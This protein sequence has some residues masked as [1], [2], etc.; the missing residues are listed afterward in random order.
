MR[1]G[2]AAAAA[3]VVMSTAFVLAAPAGA[4]SGGSPA[5]AFG[6]PTVVDPLHTWGEPDVAIS[7]VD[8]TYY[9]SGPTGTGTQ[10]SMWEASTDGGRTF[11]PITPAMAPLSALAGTE[12][13]PGGGDTDLAFDHTGKQYFADLYALT[14]F[15]MATTSDDGASVSQNVFPGGCAGTPGADRQWFAMFD[16][17]GGV[18]SSAYRGPFPLLYMEYRGEASSSGANWVRSNDGLKWAAAGNPSCCPD[19]YPSVDQ[20]TGRILQV[21]AASGGSLGLQIGTPDASGNLTFLPTPATVVPAAWMNAHGSPDDLFTVSSLDRGRNLWVFFVTE[22]SNDPALQQTWVTVAAEKTG[23]RTWAPPVQVSD[24]S[25][26][27][28]DAVNLMPWIKAGSA[29]LA[30]A[31]WYGSGP[32]SNGQLVDANAI[33]GQAW[34]VFMSQLSWPVDSTGAVITTRRPAHTLTRVSPHPMHYN[35]VCES[36]T[37]CII[38]QGNRNLADF[39]NLAIDPQ[40]AAVIVYDD[41]SNQLIQTG[42]PTSEQ[43][44][45]HQGA[46]VVTIAHQSA[47]MGVYGHLVSG[48][49]N[50][51]T[52]SMTRSAGGALFPVIGGTEVP[53]MDLTGSTV[54]LS[55]DGSTLNISMKVADLSSI[56]NTAAAVQAPLLSFVT[57]WVMHGSGQDTIYYAEMETDASGAAPM[58]YAGQAQSVDLCSVSACF[59]HVIT[60]PEVGSGS[61]SVTGALD[62]SS[63]PC[64]ISMSVPA[65]DVGSPGKD[66]RLEEVG[67]YAFAESHPMVAITNAQAQADNVPL[68]IGGVCCYDYQ[69]AA[70]AAP[71]S[72]VNP[73][74]NL[75][76]QVVSALGGKGSTAGNASSASGSGGTGT[77]GASS[78]GS[79]GLG[80]AAGS[81]SKAPLAQSTAGRP[82]AIIAGA[83]ALLLLL[84]GLFGWLYTTRRHVANPPP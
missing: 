41:T 59:P 6:T 83:A 14:C 69:E 28:G 15:R 23:W 29:G 24:G 64:T 54:S 20:A 72:S 27:T 18:T 32:G 1:R 61:N 48:R 56:S 60:Y 62:C 76:N 68:E 22:N 42:F 51:A 71:P 12:D 70:L 57:R 44:V 30:D 46:P 38:S 65:A 77:P 4:A 31:V 45:D 36:G 9:S 21:D 16:P 5:I 13:P 47:G 78:G 35:D 80:G 67:A 26:R 66:S 33:G 43:V 81:R 82:A 19:G 53:G 49:S 25:I 7:P 50:A 37:G 11:R 75:I 55:G 74:Q 84:V 58:F 10:R 63:K 40:G 52:A 39:F 34:N 17:P 3:F 8:G 2:L 73:I 79:H